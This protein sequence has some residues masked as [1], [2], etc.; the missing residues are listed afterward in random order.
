[1]TWTVRVRHRWADL[2]DSVV[3]ESNLAAHV[4]PDMWESGIQ[5]AN[6]MSGGKFRLLRGSSQ[7]RLY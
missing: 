6:E 5:L 7:G 4:T 3:L 2:V 1:M